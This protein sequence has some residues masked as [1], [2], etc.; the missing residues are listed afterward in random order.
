MLASNRIGINGCIPLGTLLLSFIL[1]LGPIETHAQDTPVDG[2][3]PSPE[4]FFG[5]QMGADRQLA[6]WDRLVEYYELLG[7]ASDRIVVEEVGEVRLPAF[8][9]DLG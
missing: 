2:A 6:R 9:E 5:H 1:A 8:P 3:I 4:E 7:D